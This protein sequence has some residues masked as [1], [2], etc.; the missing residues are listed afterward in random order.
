MFAL[1]RVILILVFLCISLDPLDFSKITEQIYNYVPLSYASFCTRKL[2]LT[3]QVGCSSDINGNSGVALFMNESQDII[4]TLSSD[5][6]TSFVVVVNVGQFV[7]TSLMRYF[8]STTNIKGL[9]VFSNE[10]EN[11]D[12]YAFSESSKCPNS[13]YS[14][15]NFTDQCDLD[16]QWN[17]AGTEYS[18]I[19]WPF[20][21]V[22]VADVNNTIW[23]SMYKCFS[24]LNREPADDTRCLIEIN[25]PMSAVGSSETCFRRQYLMSLHISES[26]EIFCDE[27]TGLNII[28]S[29][30]DSKNHSRDNNISN[31][32]RSENSSVFVLTRMDSRSI[33]ERSGFSSQGVL[34]SIAVLISVAVHLMGQKTLKDS[35]FEK[36]L[37]FSFLDNEAYDF[38]GSSRF[39]YDL[40][41]GN[42]AR[43]TGDPVIWNNVYAVIELGELGLSRKRDNYSMFFMLT[44]DKTYNVTRNLTDN[45][46]HHLTAASETN[47]KVDIKRPLNKLRELPLPPISSMQTLLQNSPRPLP[48]VVLSDYDRPPFLNK[49][50]E[51][52]LDTR[53][54]PLDNPTADTI[55]LDFA[56][57][58][59]D[60]LHRIVSA[61]HEP[62]SSSIAYPKPSDIMECFSTN[63]GCDLFKMYLSPVDYKYVQMLKTPVPAQ[64]YLPLGLHEIK[65][66]H[67]VSILLIGLTGERTSTPACPPFDKRGPY[68]YWMGYFNGSEQCYFTRMDITSQF[69]M[70]ENEKLKAPAWMRSRE[71][72]E[73]FLRWYRGASPTVDGFSVALGIFL[74]T[75]T[76]LIALY[77]KE[78]INKKIIQIPAQMEILYTS[79]NENR[80]APT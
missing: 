62:I 23:T 1:H 59:A 57:T 18:Y 47:Q 36:D 3:G 31:Y 5:I 65:I 52:F 67:L 26:S 21:V 79:D 45:I 72:S 10:G 24:M 28:L 66:S 2:N 58:L 48:H 9:I 8:R 53:W 12:S 15:Y 27:L 49:H 6:S 69:L 32:A 43:Y 68:T 42:I 13:D 38:M 70:M 16:A 11:Y 50:F 61:N 20:P 34:P 75:L 29:V 37:L 60:A 77:I 41:S 39:S 73:R 19:S 44:D 25:N 40:S 35:Q 22:L 7:N 30:T 71:H 17:P 56:N 80:L 64:T 33:F 55:L 14:A 74:M 51:S 76:L 4:Q 63:L 78:V 54:P 46:F